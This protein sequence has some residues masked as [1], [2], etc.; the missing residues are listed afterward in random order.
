MQQ[1]ILASLP[2]KSHVIFIV[3][4]ILAV[5]FVIFPLGPLVDQITDNKSCQQ[6]Q[7]PVRIQLKKKQKSAMRFRFSPR[8]TQYMVTNVLQS[9]Q[10]TLGVRKC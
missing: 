3:K 7:L 6:T 1:Q 4:G 9:Q 5:Q 2:A 8:C 10:Y